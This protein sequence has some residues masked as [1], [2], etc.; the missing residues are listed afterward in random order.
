VGFTVLQEGLRFL[1]K[2]RIGGTY[3]AEGK[4]VRGK[5][6]SAAAWV[7]VAMVLA[8]VA[9]GAVVSCTVVCA[10]AAARAARAA[11]MMFHTFRMVQGSRGRRS[12][13]REA[14]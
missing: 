7:S 3:L 11:A 8:E 12:E 5:L 9:E 1:E 4:R 13:I 10:A 6:E 14:R 2:E